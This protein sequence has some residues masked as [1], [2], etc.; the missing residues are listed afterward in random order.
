MEYAGLIFPRHE[1]WMDLGDHDAPFTVTDGD[2][3]VVMQLPTPFDLDGQPAG[4]LRRGDRLSLSWEG[5][6]EPMVWITSYTC[7][8]GGGGGVVGDTIDDDGSLEIAVD[9]IADDIGRPPP[10]MVGIELSRVREGTV[11]DGFRAERGTAIERR[12]VSFMLEP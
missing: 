9:R 4:P 12:A 1:G 2:H 3:D 5:A 7:D 8:D 11:D 10:C 6:G